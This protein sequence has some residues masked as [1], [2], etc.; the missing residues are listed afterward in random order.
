MRLRTPPTQRILVIP[1]LGFLL[2]SMLLSGC[3][4]GGDTRADPTP[5][6]PTATSALIPDVTATSAETRPTPTEVP[7]RTVTVTMTPRPYPDAVYAAID[8]AAE[9]F[10]VRR[11]QIAVNDYVQVNW[12]STA[13]GCP[14]EGKFYAQI[15]TPGY[16]VDLSVEGRQVTYHTNQTGSSV[17]RC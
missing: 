3:L 11:D 14:E 13:L 4:G 7:V 16:E 1:G 6:D 17:V 10:E 5:V 8:M 2:I 12:P 9:E 15:V